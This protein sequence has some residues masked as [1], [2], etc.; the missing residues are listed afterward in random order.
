MAFKI[1]KLE[2]ETF[3]SNNL[4]FLASEIEQLDIIGETGAR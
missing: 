2:K 1:E 4:N 3:I